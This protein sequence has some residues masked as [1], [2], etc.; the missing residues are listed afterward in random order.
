MRVGILCFGVLAVAATA[1]AQRNRDDDKAATK[2]A[3]SVEECFFERDIREFEVVDQTHVIVFTGPQRCAFHVELRGTMCDLTF[4]PDLDFSRRGDLSSGGFTGAE[5]VPGGAAADPFDP[6]ESARRNDHAL[7]ICSN[8]LA[9]QV[10]GGR[11][12][13]SATTNVATDRFGNPRTDCQVMTVT[14]ITDDQLVEF[15]VGRGVLP[16][17][18]PMG[19]GEIEVGEQDEPDEPEAGAADGEAPPADEPK[20]RGKRR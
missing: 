16:P 17:L 8:D 19:T 6:L 13:E 9:I 5:P 18:P 14:S 20:G 10:T 7:R 15:Y 1:H 4:A 12:T 11:F 2:R 3:C